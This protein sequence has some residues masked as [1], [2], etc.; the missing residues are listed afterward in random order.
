[1][2]Q[3]YAPTLKEDPVD[4]E[5]ASHRL[6][7]RAAMI[8]KVASGVYSFLP[9][10]FKSLQKLE[11]IVREEMEAIGSQELRMSIIQPAELWHE[12]GRWSDYGPELF[13]LND[14]H[15]HAFALAP[16]HEELITF[17]IRNELRSYRELPK[18]LFHIT[19]KYRDEIR[20]RFGLLRGREFVMKDAYSFHATKESLQETYDEMAAAYGRICERLGLNYY[21][22][23]ADSGQIG[24][25]VTCEFM[26][27]ADAGE[28]EIAHCTCGYAA[29][30]E[31]AEAHI[32]P[33]SHEAHEGAALSKI[34]TPIEG[35]IA[36]LAAFLGIPEEAT[37]KALSV[38]DPEGTMSVLFI[39]GD[40]ELA[41]VKTNRAIPGFEFLT[42][43]EML[44]AGLVKGFMGPVGL[45]KGVRVVADISLKDTRRW[46]VGANEKDHHYVGAAQGSDFTVDV[47]ADLAL[48]QAGDCCS[49]C[50]EPLSFAR[51]IEVGQ[52]FQLGTKYSE[53]MAA[54][55]M[56]E[57]GFEKPFLMGCY[58]WGVT[59]SLAA[60]VEQHNDEGGI[61]W[62]MSIAPAEVAVLPLVMGDDAVEPT[63]LTIAEE[64]CALGIEVVIDDRFERAGVK[65]N[66]ADLIGWPYQVIVGKRG[67]E[68]GA[69]EF[70]DRQSGEKQQLA[71]DE[72]VVLIAAAVKDVR[73]R[74]L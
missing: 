29:N 44:K 5:I 42:D 17:L 7:V 64:L 49:V 73:A 31:V 34:H 28:A 6:L 11:Q 13:R 67:L 58:G 59:R 2:S 66:D 45:P 10:G 35:T 47:W 23:E 39:P 62:P 37:V 65:F 54:Y 72:A 46:V 52:V 22:V 55:F 70:K 68:A 26:A 53:S 3:L 69:V 56:D 41:E 9:L 16:T 51:G 60:V 63:A 12:S 40:H 36:A 4:A 18:S 27:L 14:R 30:T 38:K 61:V 8:R 74:Y 15:E 50:D 33:L 20:P 21:P 19:N 24:G 57:D 71:L 1:M 48:A 43:D 25:K 32:R